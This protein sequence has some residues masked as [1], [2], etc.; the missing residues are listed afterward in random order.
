MLSR[1]VTFPLSASTSAT[2]AVTC[3]E[4]AACRDEIFAVLC[5]T[6]ASPLMK[7]LSAP[8]T[9]TL[10]VPGPGLEHVGEVLLND[11]TAELLCIAMALAPNAK[12]KLPLAL[13]LKP[14]ANDDSP[15]AELW[16]PPAVTEKRAVAMLYSPPKTADA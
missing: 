4:T 12:L 11:I 15:P 5:S 9:Q 14:A 10:S 13:L 6:V 16:S 7:N 3:A 1:V 2:T 8:F